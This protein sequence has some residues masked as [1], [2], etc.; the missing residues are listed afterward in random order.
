MKFTKLNL[1]SLIAVLVAV[2]ALNG[3]RILLPDGNLDREINSKY[4]DFA[5][6]LVGDNILVYTS[7]KA[8]LSGY[9]DNES[10]KGE[11]LFI[12][13][14]SENLWQEGKLFPMD[15]P[16]TGLNEGVTTILKNGDAVVGRAYEEGG[17]GG[18]DL[19]SARYNSGTAEIENL[20]NLGANINSKYWEAHPTLLNDGRVLIFSSDRPGGLGGSDLWISYK[21]GNS[22]S[23]PKNMGKKFNTSGDEYSPFV[24]MAV[25][26]LLLFASNGRGDT[27]GD[28][29]IYYAYHKCGESYHE[30]GWFDIQ[31]LDEKINTESND[32]FPFIQKTEKLYFASEQTGGVG[33]YD[34]Y[35]K[36]VTLPPP[37]IPL[38]GAILEEGS[39]QPVSYNASIEF[40]NTKT[41]ERI[42][43]T[44]SPPESKYEIPKLC[45]GNYRV[46][47]SA[48]RYSTLNVQEEITLCNRNLNYKITPEGFM[49]TGVV[50]DS[51]TGK[52]VEMAAKI[53][54][55][56]NGQLFFSGETTPPASE[57]S[58]PGT[59]PG[60]FIIKIS[61][62]NA[63]IVQVNNLLGYWSKTEEVLVTLS[64]EKLEHRVIP[65]E[66]PSQVK[67]YFVTGYYRMN[68]RKNLSDLESFLKGKLEKA[69]YIEEPSKENG[70]YEKYRKT[71]PEIEASL[72]KMISDL[73]LKTFPIMLSE[74]GL[75]KKLEL[76][77]WGYT[78]PREII[79]N[80]Y[81]ENSV[82]HPDIKVD[83][84]EVMNNLALS[85]LR[86][87]Y[88]MKHVE[89]LLQTKS[90]KYKLVKDRVSF[91]VE[92]KGVDPTEITFDQRRHVRIFFIEK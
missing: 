34:L 76:H 88:S 11:D 71:S 13:S 33:G 14:Y 44:T 47:V 32:A 74:Q 27:Y 5:P 20:K 4:D 64:T 6:V 90:E 40:V 73:D 65:F 10:K 58:I 49:L 78:D 22:W 45:N 28:L 29:D 30:N 37:C 61:F 77:I 69:T 84:K 16:T 87:Y 15:L 19:Y 8:C 48:D 21:D 38:S 81:Y 80:L 52:P 2:V 35:A 46:T 68:T 56:K 62:P 53:D 92:G 86:A 24:Y 79:P 54:V 25:D 51:I 23:K 18:S 85:K 41:G 36:P 59:T 72:D 42:T 82:Q 70:F 57:Y 89:Q 66:Y 9:I 75:G 67:A 17:F 63:P 1:I 60:S 7:N 31:H 39:N 43:K 12:S 55:Y 3:C 50:L 83:K 91:V 26:T